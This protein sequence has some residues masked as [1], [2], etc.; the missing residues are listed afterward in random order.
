M[1]KK[2]I[3]I[4]SNQLDFGKERR[5]IKNFIKNDPLYNNYFEVFIFEDTPANGIS[6]QKIYLDK[7]RDSDIFIGLIGENYGNKNENGISATEEEFNEFTKGQN[8]SNTYMFILENIKKDKSTEKFIEKAKNFTYSKFTRTNFEEKIKKSLSN[9][10]EKNKLLINPEFDER[11]IFSGSCSDIDIGEV[12]SFLIKSD[13]SADILN[14]NI[15]NTLLNKLQVLEKVNNE[16]K[17]KNVAILFFGKNI[18]RFIPQHEIRLT[19]FADNYGT[20]ILDS[21]DLKDPIFPLLKKCKNFIVSNTKTAQEIR[22]LTEKTLM[23]TL[24]QL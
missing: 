16:I 18:G 1:I 8:K 12:K 15:K 6:P 21:V 13:L 3:F 20:E 2:K 17:P 7:V 11:I 22:D 24:M 19:K 4:S 14:E 9:F 5:E 23:N 10:L